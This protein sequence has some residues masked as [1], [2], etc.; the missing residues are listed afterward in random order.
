VVARFDINRSE[1]R[2]C[3]DLVVETDEFETAD[4]ALR[5]EMTITIRGG[6]RDEDHHARL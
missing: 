2:R 4:P 5:G 3:Q 1:L 6:T